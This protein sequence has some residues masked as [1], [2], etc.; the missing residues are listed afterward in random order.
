MRRALLLALAACAA[1]SAR[2]PAPNACGASACQVTRDTFT[3]AAPLALD[4]LFVLDN[5]RAT[6]PPRRSLATHL[7]A[8]TAPLQAVHADLHV[9]LITTDLGAG[10]GA[11]A[12]LACQPGGDGG[13]LQNTPRGAGCDG[14]HLV[15]PANRFLAWAPDPAGGAPV[16]NFTGSLPEA[17][18]CYA[19]LASGC[20]AEHQL[21]AIGAALDG[22][23]VAG[24]CSVTANNGFL[25]PGAFL[26]VVILTDEDDCSAPP[27][28]TL[29]DPSPEAA[30]VLG[31]LTSYR[32]FEYGVLCHGA[33]PGREPGSR[34]GC[35]PGSAD[36]DPAHQLI[37]VELFAA[38]LQSLKADPRMVGVAVIGGP[39]APVAVGAGVNGPDLQPS[40]ASALGAADPAIRLAAFVD[41]FA[42][43]RGAFFTVCQNDLRPPLATLAGRLA[44]AAPGVGAC[45]SAPLRNADATGRAL[46]P[47]CTVREQAL[48]A[49]GSSREIPRC[50][51]VVCDPAA[52]DC[53]R[54][55]HTLPAGA[56]A[57][58]YVW[59]D[60]AACGPARP[61][62]VASG[63][64]LR[65]DRGVYA[66]GEPVPPAAAV[67]TVVDCATCPA[68]PPDC[69]PACAWNWPERCG[70]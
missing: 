70:G 15:D 31:P 43:D 7:A 48:G 28:T 36:P 55:T 57:C 60:A 13:R 47:A 66:D 61:G 3:Q 9:G 12:A 67:E 6:D 29:F 5:S 32:C 69:S 26:Q 68:D 46:Q 51:P 37:A 27:W 21:A 42:A 25:R 30:A 59:P 64:R 65:V 4:L 40:C 34:F 45:L 23:H 63:Y 33:D 8:L 22:C 18:A 58:W 39:P 11:V 41:L 10:P 20:E 35:E 38:F 24:G 56:P 62:G 52:G 53:A 44:P 1:C 17:F 14:A 2:A 19:E 54:L 50:A 49:A 16:A